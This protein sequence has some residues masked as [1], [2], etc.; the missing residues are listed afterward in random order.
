MKIIRLER[1]ISDLANSTNIM[2]QIIWEAVR[3]HSRQPVR[4]LLKTVS[5]HLFIGHY[6]I[7]VEE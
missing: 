1:T 2:D 3:L 7:N 6:I 5:S 4:N